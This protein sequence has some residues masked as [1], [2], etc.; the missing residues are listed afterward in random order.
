MVQERILRMQQHSFIL[1]WHA[2]VKH[3]FDYLVFKRL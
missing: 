2:I 1:F 3:L